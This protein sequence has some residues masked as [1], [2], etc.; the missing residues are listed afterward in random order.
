MT[1]EQ[2]S[3]IVKLTIENREHKLTTLLKAGKITPFV[4]GLIVAKFVTPEAVAVETSEDTGNEFDFLCN[5]LTI[6]KDIS[7]LLGEKT[8]I[9]SLELPDPRKKAN[10][11]H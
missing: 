9:Q 7:G 4:R 10:D 11:A 1:E 3:T 2:T 5:I 6:N 8:G